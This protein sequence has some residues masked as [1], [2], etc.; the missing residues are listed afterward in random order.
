MAHGV[1]NKYNSI[2]RSRRGPGNAH[3]ISFR[4][5]SLLVRRRRPA[6]ATGAAN[7][8]ALGNLLINN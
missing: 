6:A 4:Q 1:Y 8:A 7:G 3:F 2:V 5:V